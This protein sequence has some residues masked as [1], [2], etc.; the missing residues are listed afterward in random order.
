MARSPLGSGLTMAERGIERGLRGLVPRWASWRLGPYVAAVMGRGTLPLGRLLSAHRRVLPDYIIIGAAKSGTSS[1]FFALKN[2]P[3]VIPPVTKE[4]HFFDHNFARGSRW[5]RA[6]FPSTDDRARGASGP[7][8]A[9]GEATPYYLAHPHA[10]ERVAGTAPDARLIALL[11]DPVDRAY[12]HYHHQV[13]AKIEPFTF[14]DAID[15]EEERV[16][17]DLR[18][19]HADPS[20]RGAAHHTYGYVSAG[21]YA[22]QLERWFRFV[23]RERLLIMR[24]ED[25]YADPGTA[26]RRVVEHIG[27]PQWQPE[28]FVHR[29]EGDYGQDMRPETRKRLARIFAP[30]NRRL[31]AIIGRD[32]GWTTDD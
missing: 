26:F 8:F 28:R 18:R 4:I 14:E 23:P 13:R 6:H 9:T 11:R 7:G 25:L 24:S 16:G 29:N 17:D 31:Y 15:A 22:D 2:H 1:L 5:Y 19:L 32:L 3:A 27:L 10:P 21:M 12:S 20:H 30:H